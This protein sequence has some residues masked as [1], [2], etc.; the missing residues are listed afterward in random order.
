MSDHLDLVKWS[1]CLFLARET[2]A[3]WTFLSTGQGKKGF[4]KSQRRIGLG[5]GPGF[6]AGSARE[7]SQH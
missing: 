4:G 3:I 5:L 1:E 7:A 6:E 2:R